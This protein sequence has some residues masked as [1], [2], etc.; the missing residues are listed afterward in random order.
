[1]EWS[2][3]FVLNSILLGVGLTMDAFS[4]SVGYD[5]AYHFSKLFKKHYG[6]SPLYYRTSKD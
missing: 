2:L 4:V 5:D 3:L 6:I 1:M